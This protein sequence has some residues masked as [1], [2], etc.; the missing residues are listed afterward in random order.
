MTPPPPP[1]PQQPPHDDHRLVREQLFDFVRQLLVPLFEQSSAQHRQDSARKQQQWLGNVGP[2]ITHELIDR[3]TSLLFPPEKNVQHAVIRRALCKLMW[4]SSK[5]VDA[6]EKDCLPKD[7][8]EFGKCLRKRMREVGK[9]DL[10]DI[11]LG[12]VCTHQAQAS[13]NMANAQ[14]LHVVLGLLG[15]AGDASAALDWIVQDIAIWLCHVMNEL[16][17]GS[18]SSGSEHK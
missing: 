8:V 11:D 16:E 7:L 10:M 12:A 15:P 2:F 5:N 6:A 1:H 17:D 13:P 14:Q 18:S 9:K 3:D 4:W